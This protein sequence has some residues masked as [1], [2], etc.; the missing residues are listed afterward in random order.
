MKPEKVDSMLLYILEL[1][2]K[3]EPPTP[4]GTKIWKESLKGISEAEAHRAILHHYKTS[5]FYPHLSDILSNLTTEKLKALPS[6]D[7]AWGSA[8]KLATGTG[9]IDSLHPATIKAIRRFGGIEAL[10]KGNPEYTRGQFLKT[11][12]SV[13]QDYIDNGTPL[14]EAPK[15]VIDYGAIA[16]ERLKKELE[17]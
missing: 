4:E 10:E 2:P 9:N 12:S 14:L 7:E 15:K 5:R 11:Y 17:I 8:Y 3:F 13:T 1:Y 16:L 6:P